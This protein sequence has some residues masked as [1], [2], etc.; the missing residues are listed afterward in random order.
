[1][2]R[3]NRIFI[4]LLPLLNKEKNAIK[5][6]R[7]NKYNTASDDKSTYY[8]KVVREYEISLSGWS[9]VSNYIYIKNSELCSYAFYVSV[10]NFRPIKDFSS[11]NI[12]FPNSVFMQDYTV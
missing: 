1:M 9:T 7:K 10:K 5:I 8:C 4:F 6:V 11:L 3:K 12:C 2:Q